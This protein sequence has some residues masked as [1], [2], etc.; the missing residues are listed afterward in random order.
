[1][2]ITCNSKK[3]LINNSGTVD[4]IPGNTYNVI[5]KY[6]NNLDNRTCVV[7]EEGAMHQL[8]AWFTEFKIDK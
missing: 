6:A 1:M 8:G 3:P 5:G 4:F 2:R 7:D